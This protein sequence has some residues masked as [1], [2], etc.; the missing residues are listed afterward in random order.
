MQHS[1]PEQ[2]S[3]FIARLAPADRADLL[4]LA[5]R[6]ALTRGELIFKAGSAGDY[7]Y[8]L[9][10][11]RVKIYHLSPSGKEILLWFCFPGEIFGLAEVCHGGGRQVYA[12]TCEPS[13]VLGVRQDDFQKFLATHPPAALLVNDV[14]A[15]RLRNLGNII[16]SLVASDVNERVA[17]LLVRLAATHGQK[18]QNGDIA[19]DIRLTHQEMAN[20]IGTT[21]QSVTSALNLLRR[22]GVLEF[23]A[24][25][26]I[27]VH[28]ETL[29]TQA[30]ITAAPPTSPHS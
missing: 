29:L 16:Q 18:T 8:F 1:S 7:V 17:Q 11:G 24:N 3:D 25:H 19:L 10:S 9:E 26:H 28:S 15:C 2:L 22:Q 21:R 5:T 4:Q 20:M 13:Q 27:L 6:R 12:E 14:L 23:D 30:G